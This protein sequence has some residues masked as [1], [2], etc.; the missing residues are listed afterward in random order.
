MSTYFLTGARIGIRPFESSDIGPRY[1][2]W[3]NDPDVNRYSGRRFR[4]SSLLAAERY[5]ASIGN[6]AEIL[7]VCLLDS[8]T[9]IGNIKYGPIDWFNGCAEVEILLG[10]KSQWGKGYAREAIQLIT[11]HLFI[12]L[13]L[14]RIEGKTANP[15]FAAAVKGLGWSLEGVLRDR[16]RGED[17][18]LDYQLYS[19]LANEF[20]E[21][22]P[23]ERKRRK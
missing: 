9:H 10:D 21:S 1:L 16:F 13:G 11:R 4:P 2:A 12:T 14:H 18:Y 19:L 17:G 20:K 7:A 22:R 23:S 6:D 5:L 15:A 8:G 3:L